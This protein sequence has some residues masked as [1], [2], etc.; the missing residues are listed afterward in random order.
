MYCVSTA[1]NVHCV[2]IP[3]NPHCASTPLVKFTLCV[4]PSR[5]HACSKC[6]LCIHTP[7][8]HTVRLPLYEIDTVYPSPLLTPNAHCVSTP[9]NSHC[10]CYYLVD[11]NVMWVQVH[12]RIYNTLS[13]LGKRTDS[14]ERETHAL[15]MNCIGFMVERCV[16][17]GPD[18]ILKL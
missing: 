7:K 12:C 18:S 3:L 15:K 6:T 16:K 1:P 2:F 5:I 4:H 14:E 8:M 10:A 11:K 17:D 13:R 9:P